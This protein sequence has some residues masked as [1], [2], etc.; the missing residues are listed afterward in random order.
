[1]QRS[2]GRHRGGERAE[3]HRILDEFVAVS[4][5]HSE[6]V[7]RLL[8]ERPDVAPVRSP[9]HR[10]YGAAVREAL[11]VRNCSTHP[12][13]RKRL[14]HIAFTGRH[15]MLSQQYRIHERVALIAIIFVASSSVRRCYV[16]YF[17]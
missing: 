2:G 11:I 17:H 12:H 9:L 14:K 5:Y 15:A 7:V 13:C 4:G 6:H 1:M 8:R 3:K 16:P 10:V